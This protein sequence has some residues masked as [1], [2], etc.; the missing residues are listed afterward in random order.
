MMNLIRFACIA[1]G[2]IQRFELVIACGPLLSFVASE[3]L[4]TNFE[5]FLPLDAIGNQARAIST[6]L[7]G[8]IYA[9]FGRAFCAGSG[10]RLDQMEVCL[11]VMGWDG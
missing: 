8:W 9:G 2:L 5:V 6:D 11:A 1:E 4:D 3:R 7:G 10:W